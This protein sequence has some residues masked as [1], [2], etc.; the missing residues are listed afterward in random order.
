MFS[1]VAVK[2]DYRDL[3]AL[4]GRVG[5]REEEGKLLKLGSKLAVLASQAAHLLF[6]K[7]KLF[8]RFVLFCAAHCSFVERIDK[9]LLCL[10]DLQQDSQRPSRGNLGQRHRSRI[11]R[12]TIAGTGA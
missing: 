4:R 3:F 1:A 2:V 8:R 7:P 9:F 6:Q 5:L 10:R 11:T 12:L